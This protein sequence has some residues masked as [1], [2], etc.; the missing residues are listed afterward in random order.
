MGRWSRKIAREFVAWLDQPAGLMWLDVGCGTG[1]LTATIFA[2]CA[3]RAIVAIDPSVPFIDYARGTLPA[4]SVRF[5]V[6]SASAL[7]VDDRSI[8]V[9]ASGLALNFFAD[10]PA[11]FAEMQRVAKPT[12][13]VAFYV[14]DYPGGGMGFM[15]AFWEAAMA[16]APGAASA[17]ER[18]RFPFCTPD[19]LLEELRATGFVQAEVRAIEVAAL[20]ADFDDLWTPFT[21]GTGPAPAYYQRLDAETRLALKRTLQASVGDRV[22]IEFPA[23]AWALRG[24]PG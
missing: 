1:A 4:D 19:G 12:A 16:V 6:A 17:E 7:P 24:R 18:S 5:E 10:R 21:Q 11:A 20:F 15:D 14:W 22:P 23:R 9:V 2:E 3:P 8:D 13:T